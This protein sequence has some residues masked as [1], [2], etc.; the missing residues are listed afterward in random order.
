MTILLTLFHVLISL[1]LI[2]IVLLQTG[3]GSDLAS[4]FGGG[5]QNAMFGGA[6]PA[7]FL[8]KMTTAVAVLF[9]ATSI[10][11][12]YVATGSDSIMQGEE[13][14]VEE[15]VED[16]AAETGEAGEAGTASEAGDSAEAIPPSDAG[17][18][19]SDNDTT[20]A[21]PVAPEGQE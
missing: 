2:M 10:T 20:S 21:E 6:G 15:S 17:T 11:L 13:P 12:A 18:T 3:K 8:N 16:L 9:M 19:T 14:V 5:G 7:S 1:A 4:A